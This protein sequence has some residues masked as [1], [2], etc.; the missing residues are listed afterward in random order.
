MDI[1]S[2]LVVY[3][4]IIVQY[5]RINLK[6]SIITFSIFLSFIGIIKMEVI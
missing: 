2:I 4:L 1:H 5:L 6:L 3:I